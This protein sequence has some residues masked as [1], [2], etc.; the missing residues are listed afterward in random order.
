M[1]ILRSGNSISR[2]MSYDW[3]LFAFKSSRP[4]THCERI[5][6]LLVAVNGQNIFE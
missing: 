1:V 3:N 6:T 4:F 2:A 5:L